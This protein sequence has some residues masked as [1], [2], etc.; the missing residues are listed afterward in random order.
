[1]NW[2]DWA[3]IWVP[4]AILVYTALKSQKYVKGVSDFLA[5]G[6]VAR[7]YVLSVAS[8]EANM[9][10]ISVVAIMEMYYKSGFAISFWSSLTAPISLVMGLVGFCTYR[11]RETR[12]L[13][14]GQFFEIRYNKQLRVVASIIQSISGIINYAIFPAVG[15]RFLIYFMDLPLHFRF[16]GVTWTTFGVVMGV[17]LI[18]ALVITTMGGQVT[19]MVTDCVQGLLSYP[20]FVVI[21]AFFLYKFSWFTEMEPALQARAPAESFLNPYDVQNLRDFNLF[22]VFVGIVSLFFSRMSWGG[23]QGYNGAAKTP[24]EAKMGGLLGTWR[25]QLESL[26]YILIAVTAYTYLNHADFASHARHVRNLL[27]TKTIEDVA[28][29]DEHKELRE[30]L[31]AKFNAIPERTKFSTSYATREDYLAE[32]ADPYIETVSESLKEVKGGAETTQKFQTIYNQMLVPVAIREMLPMYGITGIFCALMIFLMVST[33]TTYMHSW[34]S[35]IIQDFVLPLRKKPFTPRGQIRALRISIAFVC[36]FAFIFSLYFAQLDYILMFFAITG[37]IWSGAG[38]VITLGLYWKRGTTLGAF[39]ALISGAVL[40]CTGIILQQNWASHIYPW[41][42]EANLAVP[43][44]NFLAK[45]SAPFNPYIVWTMN[46]QKFPINSQEIAFISQVTAICFYIIPSF[47]VKKPF[48]MDRMLHRGIYS[49]SHNEAVKQ[50]FSLKRFFATKILG[51]DKNYTF[52]D[53]ILANSVFIWSFVYG[54]G[55]CFLMVVIWNA[56]KPWPAEWWGLYFFIKNVCVTGILGIFT[57]VWFGICGTRDLCYLF[58]DLKNKKEDN[59]L[60]DGRVINNVSAAD[61]NS[62]NVAEMA[63][64]E[65]KD[66][67]TSTDNKSQK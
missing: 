65:A 55:I 53:K 36:A 42:V 25:G 66:T 38:V 7:R 44:G 2:L 18:L 46:P 62:V 27:A 19:I 64:K 37:A 52:G 22:Y 41:L 12:A 40:S 17:A 10:L 21:V 58:K 16:L 51:I 13:T 11:F 56:I 59:I 5:A 26:M 15:A 1:M 34:G 29:G 45:V 43:I 67:V 35:I 31:Y 54:F 57:T 63:A 60:D 24:H 6:R 8:G 48:N 33:D 14:M 23:A 61:L 32:N 50:P 47:F 4:I 3:I 28:G 30:T 9:G 20:M 49:D 39:L